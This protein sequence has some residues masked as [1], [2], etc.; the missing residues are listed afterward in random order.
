MREV[1]NLTRL[2]KIKT[3]KLEKLKQEIVAWLLL[4]K[5]NGSTIQ[6]AQVMIKGLSDQITQV[7]LRLVPI[8]VRCEWI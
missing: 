1:P 5:T 2:I 3:D 4:S 6:I 8:D 7:H